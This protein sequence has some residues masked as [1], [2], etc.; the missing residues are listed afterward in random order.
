MKKTILV[1]VGV[2]LVLTTFV[3]AHGEG[4]FAEAEEIIKQKAPCNELSDEQ[5]EHIGEYYMEQ[6]HPGEAHKQMDK[7]MG[8]EG[9]ESLKQM[10][11]NM[12]KAF[13]CGEHTAMSGSMMDMMMGDG[14]MQGGMM[15]SGMMNMMMGRQGMMNGGGKMMD[16]YG[17][18]GNWGFSGMILY[19]VIATAII[20]FIFGIVFWWTYKLI[21]VSKKKR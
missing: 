7:M 1:L 6:M 16:G 20:A 3:F 2:F 10:H 14:M 4:D 19:W 15:D 9:S 5:L 12:A 13:Y 21:V 17:M 8:G 18:M 11:I